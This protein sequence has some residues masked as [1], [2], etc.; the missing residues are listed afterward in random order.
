[1]IKG[2]TSCLFQLSK[3]IIIKCTTNN[4]YKKEEDKWI[5]FINNLMELIGIF[6]QIRDDLI[7][8]TSNE[9]KNLRVEYEDFN[10]GSFL[11]QL[12]FV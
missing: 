4:I 6:F 5:Q 11:I 2:K 10:E 7:S 12:L 8:I 9:Y 1:M 3:K